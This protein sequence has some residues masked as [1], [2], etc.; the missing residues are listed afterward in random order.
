MRTIA[1]LLACTL[2]LILISGCKKSGSPDPNA[3]TT[4]PRF[5]SLVSDKDSIK[6]GGTEPAILTCIAEGGNISYVW[7]V[8][9]GDLFPLNED[10]SVV[11]FTGSECCLGKKFIKCTIANDKGSCMDTV[12][13]TIYIP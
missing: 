6:V 8:D 12:I 11:R 9:L 2:S 3:N 4:F 1:F 13:V 5:L 7:E 10:G